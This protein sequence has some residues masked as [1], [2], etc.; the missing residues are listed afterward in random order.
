VAAKSRLGYDAA[1]PSVHLGKHVSEAHVRRQG[2]G[3]KTP[4]RPPKVKKPKPVSKPPT[5]SA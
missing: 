3:D 1:V 2:M 5:K 4:K